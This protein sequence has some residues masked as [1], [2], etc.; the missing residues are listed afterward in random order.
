MLKGP[1]AYEKC[2]D[3]TGATNWR[4][5]DAD[6]FRVATCYDSGN[7]QA[8]TAMLN[9]AHRARKQ[10]EYDRHKAL[11]QLTAEAQEMGFYDPPKKKDANP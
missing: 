9:S 4:I 11:D 6:G 3:P 7:A 8:V 2:V 1:F 5:S 10:L